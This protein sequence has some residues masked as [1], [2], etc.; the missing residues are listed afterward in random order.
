ME[1]E[2]QPSSFTSLKTLEARQCDQELTKFLSILPCR[3]QKLEELTVEKCERLEE[4]FDPKE[5]VTNEQ[6]NLKFPHLNKIQLL[7]LPNLKWIWKSDPRGILGLGNLEIIKCSLIS[8]PLLE[9]LD[10][11]KALK[12][13]SCDMIEQIVEDD[14]EMQERSFQ[15]LEDLELVNLQK[16]I[17]FNSG[18]CNFRFPNLLRLTIENCPQLDAFT[19]GFLSNQKQTV[20]GTTDQVPPNQNKVR[21]LQ[22]NL[23]NILLA[24]LDLASGE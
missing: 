13:V 16:L 11:L 24:Y 19:A 10:A 4:I 15:N 22:L 21:M 17:K 23:S 9:K 12:I 18:H 1:M 6:G 5:F 14:V 8:T 3:S 7:H 2:L 20:E